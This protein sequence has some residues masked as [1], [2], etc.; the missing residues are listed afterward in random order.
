[1]KHFLVERARTSRRY[2]K[3]TDPP[4]SIS[5]LNILEF[6]EEGL[7][8]QEV[9]N[10][11]KAG[12][13][14]GVI[15]ESGMPGIADPGSNITILAHQNNLK[16]CSL[17]GPSSIFLA[18]SSSGLNGQNFCFHGYLPIK[19]NELKKKVNLIEQRVYK[20]KETQIFIETPYRNNR[21]FNSLLKNL[22]DQ[23]LLCVAVDLTSNTEFVKTMSIASWKKKPIITI[24]KVP[25]IF[26]IG[27]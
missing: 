5:D 12:L 17:V 14:V 27:I 2:I 13:D 21:L 25:A 24:E 11:L 23:T 6:S 18:L 20:N 22:K 26:L 9:I 10:W 16:V 7:E 1:L 15:S 8:L 4:Y 3:L 19:E